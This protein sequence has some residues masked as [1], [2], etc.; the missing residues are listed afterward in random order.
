MSDGITDNLW[1]HGIA[2][3]AVDSLNNWTGSDAGQQAETSVSGNL[4]EGMQHVAQEIVLA[5]RKIAEDPF[6]ASPFIERA[7]G[8]GLA[9]EGGKL[10]DISV[11]AA[12]CK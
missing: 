2:D 11:E 3:T 9:I 6:A 5:A 10:D 7:V 1:E 12:V 8:E 4:A